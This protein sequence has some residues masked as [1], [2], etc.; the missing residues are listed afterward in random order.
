MH[1]S[2]ARFS[3]SFGAVATIV[4]V[5]GCGDKVNPNIVIPIVQART[6]QQT[7]LVADVASLGALTVDP[8]L[9]NPWGLAFGSTGILWAANNGSGTSTLYAQ[10]GA[11]QTLTVTIP[12]AT[13]GEAGV[14]TGTLFNTTTDFV[15][16][17]STAAAFIFAGEDGTIAAWNAASGSTASVVADRSASSAVYKGIAMASNAGANFLYL[18]NFKQNSID[19]FDASYTFVRGFTDATIPA[20]FAPFGIQTIDGNLYVT[21]AKQ[22]APDNEDDQAGAGN[23]YVDIFSP[24]GTLIRRF[25][26]QGSLNSPWGIAVAPAGFGGLDGDIL[27]GNFGDGL[28][29]AYNPTTGAFVDFLRMT[30]G[31]QISIPGL[32]SLVFAPG[33]STTLFFSSGP[34]SE[35]HG[36]LGTLTPNP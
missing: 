27:I 3:A 2:V 15:I 5:V 25:A 32:W 36:L 34:S 19:V 14:P 4:A 16:P 21:Y 31:T 35:S 24:D 1:R 26:S 23:G 10:D 6:F 29:G 18:T 12:G 9:V 20:G 7:N 13:A 8:N 11:K 30:G 17:G 33:S 22:L 28:I